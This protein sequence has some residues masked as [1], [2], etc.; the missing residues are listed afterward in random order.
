MSDEMQEV[1][2]VFS[3]YEAPSYTGPVSE[4]YNQEQ[5]YYF[6]SHDSSLTSESCTIQG[7]AVS[8]TCMF[9]FFNYQL[10]VHQNKLKAL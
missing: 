2:C 10:P 3:L 9:T 1:F 6:C 7:F 8:N 4:L 5:A